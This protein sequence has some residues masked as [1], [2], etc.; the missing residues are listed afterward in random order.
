M[1]AQFQASISFKME[2]ARLSGA[3]GFCSFR[4]IMDKPKKVLLV[5]DYDGGLS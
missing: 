2:A 4:T 1:F 3:V 5:I